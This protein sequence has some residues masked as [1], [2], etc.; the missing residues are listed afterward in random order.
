MLSS[1]L[2]SL[3]NCSNC[4]FNSFICLDPSCCVSR[5]CSTAA[6]LTWGEALC[7]SP[8]TLSNQVSNNSM[9]VPKSQSS[10]KF[11]LWSRSLNSF[12]FSQA[13]TTIAS[14]SQTG[15][16]KVLGKSENADGIGTSASWRFLFPHQEHADWI[17]NNDPFKRED[18]NQLPSNCKKWPL[19]T[20][21]PLLKSLRLSRWALTC[22]DMFTM[23]GVPATNVLRACKRKD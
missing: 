18:F 5:S 10:A 11:V 22:L 23:P 8:C 14:R 2:K 7:G 20:F 17:P 16:V 1:M 9:N 15:K 3:H 4:F 12:C 19:S 6:L 13:A 21:A